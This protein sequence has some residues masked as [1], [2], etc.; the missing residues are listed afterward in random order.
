M[1]CT[2]GEE[3]IIRCHESDLLVE[4]LGPGGCI[5]HTPGLSLHSPGIPV[6]VAGTVGTG[7]AFTAAPAVGLARGE[8]I[9]TIARQANRVGAFVASQR[10]GTPHYTSADLNALACPSRT[11]FTASRHRS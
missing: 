3:A 11:S 7:D 5:V 4:T 6:E 1:D 8:R 2:G 10:G 9:E